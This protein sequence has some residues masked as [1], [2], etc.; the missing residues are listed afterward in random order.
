MTTKIC[1]DCGHQ[2]PLKDFPM[3]STRNKIYHRNQCKPCYK[4]RAKSYNTKTPIVA[5]IYGEEMACKKCQIV[6]P[7]NEF[8]PSGSG[9]VRRTCIK[10]YD[11]VNSLA[12]RAAKMRLNCLEVYGGECKCCGE[13]ETVFLT[14]DHVNGDG[15]KHRETTRSGYSF[16]KW[17]KDNDYPNSIRILCYNCNWATYR[18]ECPHQRDG[19][20]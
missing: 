18:G 4:I 3:Y 17:M 2:G 10:C 6:K 9:Y 15:A 16:Y 12:I 7:L 13:Q 19:I 20:T 8:Y 1:G 14:F 11:A 5:N